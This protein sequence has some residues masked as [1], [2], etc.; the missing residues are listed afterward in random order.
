MINDT[1]F[2]IETWRD[3]AAQVGLHPVEHVVTAFLAYLA[4]SDARVNIG[5]PELAAAARVSLKTARSAVA[6][7]EAAGLL[8]RRCCALC[9]NPT[10]FEL[11]GGRP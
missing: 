1:Q 2:D 6:E 11:I 3:R 10:G 7:L 4:T 9:S 5:L 8:I